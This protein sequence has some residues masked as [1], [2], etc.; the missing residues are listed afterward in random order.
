MVPRQDRMASGLSMNRTNSKSTRPSKAAEHRRTPR[1]WRV[2]YEPRRSARFWSAPPLGRSGFPSSL[3]VPRHRLFPEQ[4]EFFKH[5]GEH[6]VEF[7]GL[8][9][10]EPVA[11]ALNCA[12]V[13]FRGKRAD[14]IL[15]FVGPHR[16]WGV[17]DPNRDDGLLHV[18]VRLVW[19]EHP[20][21]RADHHVLRR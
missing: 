8:L 11:N 5:V 18:P 10:H 20:F 4:I 19:A 3:M 13:R 2:G 7:T 12:V 9:Q 14:I 16:V 1:R 21:H 17:D 15:V 6:G